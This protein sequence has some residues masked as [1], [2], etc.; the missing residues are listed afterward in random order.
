MALESFKHQGCIILKGPEA[1]GHLYELGLY[2]DNQDTTGS[3][4]KNLGIIFSKI[5]I[6]LTLPIEP[7]TGGK[8]S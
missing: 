8:W 3:L 2:L 4:I 5:K 7:K 6:S 1:F